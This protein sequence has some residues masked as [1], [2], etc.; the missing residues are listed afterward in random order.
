MVMK[1]LNLIA[2]RQVLIVVITVIRLAIIVV[3]RVG[4]VVV[5]LVVGFGSLLRGG[6]CRNSGGGN[7]E[8]LVADGG[9]NDD[10]HI[11]TENLTD[12]DVAALGVDLGVLLVKE[13]H[14]RVVGRGDMI[15]S[16]ILGHDYEAE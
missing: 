12:V 13:S 6:G 10:I 3:I 4:G 15:T 9:R 14:V 8:R 7:R 1:C 5:G 16:I 11:D 2:P